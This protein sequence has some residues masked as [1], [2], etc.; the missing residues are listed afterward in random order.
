MHIWRTALLELKLVYISEVC[1]EVGFKYR[2]SK[3]RGV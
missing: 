2:H 1:Q 3:S